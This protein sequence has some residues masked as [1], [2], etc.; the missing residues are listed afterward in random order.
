MARAPALA[1]PFSLRCG[2]VVLSA[3]TGAT[4]LGW[5]PSCV[6]GMACWTA[7]GGGCCCWI[8]VCGL[9][10]LPTVVIPECS[11]LS[12]TIRAVKSIARLPDPDARSVNRWEQVDILPPVE[13]RPIFRCLA[14]PSWEGYPGEDAPTGSVRSRRK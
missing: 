1:F 13:I 3:S 4:V 2:A 8:W 5:A 10:A 14:A 12:V 6:A 9:E 7:A 11:L